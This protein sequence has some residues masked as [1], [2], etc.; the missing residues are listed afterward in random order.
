M[1]IDTSIT[2]DFTPALRGTMQTT[3]D[4]DGIRA[5]TAEAIA[6]V[7]DIKYMTAFKVA[8]TLQATTTISATNVTVTPTGGI[9]ATNAQAAVAELDT[10]KANIASPSFTGTVTLPITNTSGTATFNGAAIFNGTVAFANPQT[11]TNV[12]INPRTVTVATAA[13]ITPNSDTTDVHAVSALA[14]NLTINAP[15]GTPVDGQLLRIRIRDN[16]TS[17]TLTWN[18]AYT[19]INSELWAATLINKSMIW[20]FMWSVATSKWE[21]ESANPMPGAWG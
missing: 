6:G 11:F 21:V 19:A 14:G 1:S 7:D 5:T 17:R 20:T 2:V 4:A 9:S 10:E 16:G 3:T 18:A 12:R 15:T 8:Q 13:S